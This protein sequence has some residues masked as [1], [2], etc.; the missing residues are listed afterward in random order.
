MIKRL[1]RSSRRPFRDKLV[2]VDAPCMEALYL[3]HGEIEDDVVN[4]YYKKAMNV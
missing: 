4:L 1:M 2:I 3:T